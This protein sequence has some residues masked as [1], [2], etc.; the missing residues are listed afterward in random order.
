MLLLA[1]ALLV[2][3]FAPFGHWYVA[4][5]SLGLFLSLLSFGH[6]HRATLWQVVVRSVLYGLG[7]AGAGVWWMFALFRYTYQYD[8]ATSLVLTVASL[9]ALAVL[10]FAPLG[11][12]LW[13]ASRLPF[14]AITFPSA[15]VL[16]EWLRTVPVLGFPWF[17]VGTA[18]VETP[19]IGYAPVLGVFGVSWLVAFLSYALY[20]CA[21]RLTDA[22][23]GR[24]AAPARL[25]ALTAGAFTAVFAIGLVGQQV[26]WTEQ[27]DTDPISV[28][29]MQTHKTKAPQPP[30]VLTTDSPNASDGPVQIE[31]DKNAETLLNLTLAALRDSAT[32]PDVV[33]W[34][35]NA[36][37]RSYRVDGEDVIALRDRIRAEGV[38][39]LTGAA[40]YIATGERDRSYRTSLIHLADEL[41]YYH[42]QRLVPVYEHTS[43]P[44]W[45]VRM[46][47]V[48]DSGL[49]T[50][51]E[52][53][54]QRPFRVAGHAISA[55]ICFEMVFPDLWASQAAQAGAMFT[56]S[57]DD[58]ISYKGLGAHHI[59]QAGQMRAAETR[60]AVVRVANAGISA[61]I[62]PH[63]RVQEKRTLQ[64]GVILGEVSMR[65]GTTP[66]MRFGSTPVLGLS[67]GCLVLAAGVRF[68]RPKAQPA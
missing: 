14:K 33:V 37:S 67:V 18:F 36:L 55:A 68:R 7:M 30:A 15:W 21:Q 61:I 57:N 39:V 22:R 34:P 29:L 41:A 58:G 66:F 25:V 20:A 27:S 26:A 8:A 28:M 45:L 65:S 35:E 54:P 16:A 63:G 9:S 40:T 52:L 48:L 42:K 3:G 62:D 11:V 13:A 10:Y 6:R 49:V 19:L 59:F 44:T 56:V 32:P 60:R 24:T 2:F 1:G 64:A 5:V 47:P 23:T 46:L 17:F 31:S 43:F 4:F 51:P 38:S 53:Q 50:Q 12:L